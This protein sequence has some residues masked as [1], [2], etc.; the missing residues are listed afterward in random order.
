[1][2]KFQMAE[3]VMKK[4][5][6]FSQRAVF[7]AAAS[8]MCGAST[9]PASSLA[10]PRCQATIYPIPSGT[11]PHERPLHITA[12]ILILLSSLAA[13]AQSVIEGTVHD[14]AVVPISGA[15]IEL[16]R[17]NGSVARAA[18]TNPDGKFQF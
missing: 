2:P 11:Q 1:M 17:E 7:H 10:L 8:R 14:S 3:T 13:M 16:V 4:L 18:L 9:L 5:Q 12:L 15:N 6:V